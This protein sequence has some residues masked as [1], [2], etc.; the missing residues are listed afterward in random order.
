MIIFEAILNFHY[1][2]LYSSG[3]ERSLGSRNIL[4]DG[5]GGPGF[6]KRTKMHD[7]GF[8]RTINIWDII[9]DGQLVKLLLLFYYNA[10]GQD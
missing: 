10:V 1:F 4:A 6:S 2:W 8:S 5:A 7:R 3:F 9:A